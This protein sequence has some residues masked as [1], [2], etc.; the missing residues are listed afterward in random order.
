MYITEKSF[1]E[2]RYPEY[3]PQIVET[4]MF[5]DLFDKY[6][7]HGSSLSC[8]E[9]GCFPGD[10]LIYLHNKF[11]YKVYGIDYINRMD[12]IKSNFE[13]NGIKEYKLFFEDF[14]QW[15]TK[16]KFDIVFS[17]G[18]IEHFGNY[19]EVME[20]HISLLGKSGILLICLPNFRYAQYIFHLIFDYE[21]LSNHNL[22]VMDLGFFRSFLSQRDFK[23]RYLGYYGG[24]GF[25]VRGLQ[26]TNFLLRFIIRVIM[27]IGD[28]L[29]KYIKLESCLFSK[30]IVCIAEK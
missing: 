18:F 13:L 2:Q 29:N 10:Y 12:E 20:K 3:K 5:A 23:I 1:W 30:F 7:P 22:K 8:I 9:I 17:C 26:N 27:Y 11:G 15:Q 24:I 16:Q 28:V 25:W 6:L 4:V 21:N 14:T 19:K